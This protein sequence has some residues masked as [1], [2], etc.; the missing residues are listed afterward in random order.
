M[1]VVE[2]S[3]AASEFTNLRDRFRQAANIGSQAPFDEF[4]AQFELLMDRMDAARTAAPPSPE[5]CFKR[6]QEKI[7]KGDYDW[8]SAPKK[9]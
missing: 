8:D 7:K 1:R 4:K 6:A 2:L 5:W 9:R 3:R